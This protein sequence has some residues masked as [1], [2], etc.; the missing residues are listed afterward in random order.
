MGILSY[1]MDGY[2]SYNIAFLTLMPDYQCVRDGVNF[3]CLAEETCLTEFNAR[4]KV[5]SAS[6]I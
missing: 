5:E 6:E 3:S 1:A 2:L 4:L